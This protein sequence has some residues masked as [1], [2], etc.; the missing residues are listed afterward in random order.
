LVAEGWAAPEEIEQIYA[1]IRS[2][3]DE[4]IEWAE[5]SPYPDPADAFA[6][7]YDTPEGCA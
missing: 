1:G 3:V 2:E 7:V 6:G 5:N 4:A